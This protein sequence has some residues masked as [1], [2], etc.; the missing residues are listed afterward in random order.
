MRIIYSAGNRRGANVQL[1]RFINKISTNHN[2]KIAAY[3][4]SSYSFSHIDWTLDS[5]HNKYANKKISR[6]KKIIDSNYFPRV[7]VMEA[8]LF[9]RDIDDF[10]P[11]LIRSPHTIM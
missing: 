1:F 8:E 9:L 6:L 5:L 2:I 10:E 7:S 11:D 4:N 3:L